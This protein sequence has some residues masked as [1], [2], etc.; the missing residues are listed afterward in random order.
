VIRVCD[1]AGDVIETH[2]YKGD[3]KERCEAFSDNA[4]A[5]SPSYVAPI[6]PP[7]DQSDRRKNLSSHISVNKMLSEILC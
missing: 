7:K 2:E 6:A 3:F 5:C 4:L 1:E